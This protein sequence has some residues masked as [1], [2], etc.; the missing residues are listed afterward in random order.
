MESQKKEQKPSPLQFPENFQVIPEWI[1]NTNDTFLLEAA[2][3]LLTKAPLVKSLVVAKIMTLNKPEDPAKVL[4]ASQEKETGNNF[5]KSQN[6][7]EAITHYTYSVIYN[8]KESTT[9][10]NR[11]LAYTKI[12]KFQ[13]GVYD[14]TK[15]IKL[16]PNYTKAYY[17]RALCYSNLKK[18]RLALDDLLYLMNSNN[19]SKEI[20][21]EV[22]NIVNKFQKDIG[23]SNW[24]SIQSEIKSQIELAKQQKAVIHDPAEISEK[25]RVAFDE[26]AK[27]AEK[28]KEEIKSLL[29]KKDFVKANEIVMACYAKCNTFKDTF[30]DKTI[31]HIEIIK[32]MGELNSMKVL[33]DYYLAIAEEEKKK[34]N[35]K[36][37]MNVHHEKFYKTTIL[38]KEQRE[39]ATKIAEKD[40]KFEDFANSAYGFERGFNSFK[41]RNDILFD[42]L[43][44]FE[45]KKIET[46]YANSEIP[47]PVLNGII[48]CLKSQIDN[49]K[50]Y[51]D[52]FY[53]Y[54]KGF[55]KTKGFGLVKNFIKKTDREAIALILDKIVELDSSK[56]ES[57]ESLKNEYK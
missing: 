48:Q 52:L 36:K 16:N 42:F 21:A 47:F 54:F 5:M 10:C 6:F 28:I 55:T 25:Q 4:L 20:E 3:P 22:D 29:G 14:C 11:A 44:Y 31:Q 19:S 33:V 57:C 56:K 26:W 24:K 27:S 51:K 15:A 2:L 40:L 13:K 17:R 39:K 46:I 30:S 43:K 50:E 7:P 34:E 35:K 45:G 12:S 18:Y 41:N 37:N 23:E 38:S 9:Y 8:P 32:A 49:V 53:D 1:E